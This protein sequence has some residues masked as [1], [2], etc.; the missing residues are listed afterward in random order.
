M[1]TGWIAAP[2]GDARGYRLGNG[3]SANEGRQP[4]RSTPVDGRRSREPWIARTR[5]RSGRVPCAAA[6]EA[7]VEECNAAMS[8]VRSV[9]PS[10]DEVVTGAIVRET[11]RIATILV[12]SRETA[13]RWAM[14]PKPNRTCCVATRLG[15]VP[16]DGRSSARKPGQRSWRSRMHRH[17]RS[18][19]RL[20][21]PFQQRQWIGHPHRPWTRTS[22][23]RLGM[24][25]CAEHGPTPRKHVPNC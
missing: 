17:R 4:I 12:R 9:R 3:P 20:D 18:H 19:G 11:R 7:N 22:A 25:S 15:C 13:K 2:P 24:A 21:A 5:R 14:P 23:K 16:I 10:V 1:D 6:C 8:I